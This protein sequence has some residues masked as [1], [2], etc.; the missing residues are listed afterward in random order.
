MRSNAVTGR[1][2]ALIV[3]DSRSSAAL[4]GM[5]LQSA[6][7]DFEIARDGFEAILSLQQRPYSAV[8]LDYRLPGMDGVEVMSWIRRTLCSP[9]DVI[10]LSSEARSCLEQRFGP[11]GVKA[12]LSKPVAASDLCR[13]IEPG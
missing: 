3:D 12:I 9:P 4:A 1:P 8:L 5:V 10:V 2:C 13:A 6:G 11:L 7:W